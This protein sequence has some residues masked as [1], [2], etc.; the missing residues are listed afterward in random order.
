MPRLVRG[1]ENKA[2]ILPRASLGQDDIGR[3]TLGQDDIGKK[4]LVRMTFKIGNILCAQQSFRNLQIRQ[5][6]TI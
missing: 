4:R 5:N 2:E 1:T 3:K 6:H